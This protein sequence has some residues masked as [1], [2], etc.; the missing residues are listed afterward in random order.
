M[1]YRK[2]SENVNETQTWHNI[3]LSLTFLYQGNV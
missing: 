2:E 3:V 1:N